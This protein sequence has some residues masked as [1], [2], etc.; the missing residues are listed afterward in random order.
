MYGSEGGGIIPAVIQGGSA[1]MQTAGSVFSA[2]RNREAQQEENKKNRAF[3]E[4]M[5]N[6]A[7]TRAV[8]DMKNAGLNPMVMY[9]SGGAGASTPSGSA[10]TIPMENP[11]GDIAEIAQKSVSSALERKRLAKDQEIAEAQIANTLAN[12]KV[13]QTQEE[14]VKA[15]TKIINA[16]LPAVIADSAYKVHQTNPKLD[17]DPLVNEIAETPG[18]FG[19]TSLL[20]KVMRRGGN[21]EPFDNS[22][23]AYDA[24]LN[25][26][27][28][29]KE[30]EI[31]WSKIPKK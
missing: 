9:G 14:K 12:T 25:K 31:D 18:F 24:W 23:S 27:G 21:V 11:L 22:K 3:Q 2:K 16:T 28:V 20:G 29:K 7:Y 19:L 4:R 8:A 5:S 10:T 26:L 1:G 17:T 13:A 15:E 6:T 30:K